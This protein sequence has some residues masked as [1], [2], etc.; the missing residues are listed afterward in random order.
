MAWGSK[1]LAQG[2]N[3]FRGAAIGFVAGPIGF[4]AR[5]ICSDGDE[6][7]AHL[8][9]WPESE[10]PPSLAPQTPTAQQG[11]SPRLA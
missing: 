11:L 1:E 9:E 4:V 2:I 5:L 7:V 3:W 10:A 6:F 8:I